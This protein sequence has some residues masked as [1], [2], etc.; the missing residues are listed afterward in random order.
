MKITQKQIVS[1]WAES[2]KAE[3]EYTHKSQ[4]VKVWNTKR[5]EEIECSKLRHE[6]MTM[7]SQYAKDHEMKEWELRRKLHPRARAMAD[8]L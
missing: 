7:L 3:G 4:T 8:A 6:A 2:I 1:K 5:A